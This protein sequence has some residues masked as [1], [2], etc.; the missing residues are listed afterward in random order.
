MK[1]HLEIARG[2]WEQARRVVG[3]PMKLSARLGG[4]PTPQA[5]SQWEKVPA[6]HVLAIENATGISRH[7]LRPDIFGDF[8]IDSRGRPDPEE[9]A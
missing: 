5:I 9:A 3:G 6:T 1:N 7:E 8:P 2:A 4:S